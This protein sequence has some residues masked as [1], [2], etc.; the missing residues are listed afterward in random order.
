MNGQSEGKVQVWENVIEENRS[1][2]LLARE[3]LQEGIASP[4]DASEQ[5]LR[6]CTFYSIKG[7]KH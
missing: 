4:L 6:L 7:R 5:R 3:I 2:L 1:A